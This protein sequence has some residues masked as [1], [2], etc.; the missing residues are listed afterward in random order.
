MSV[1]HFTKYRKSITDHKREWKQA[2]QQPIKERESIIHPQRQGKVCFA[3]LLNWKIY[4]ILK[5]HTAKILLPI[6]HQNNSILVKK[7]LQEN[8]WAFCIKKPQTYT[9]VYL[10]SIKGG[11]ILN[12]LSWIS[13]LFLSALH[14]LS[15]Y[16]NQF[17]ILV[18]P[19]L[20]LFLS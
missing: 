5:S 11:D 2:N 9:I 18:K 7:I 16:K 17:E 8:I 20:F 10:R 13:R 12:I 4:F 15:F 3:K 6:G 19:Q 1:Y 14:R